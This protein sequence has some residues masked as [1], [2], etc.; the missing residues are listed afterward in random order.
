MRPGRR[1]VDRVNRNVFA[2]T[3][4]SKRPAQDV[5]DRPK[6]GITS[7]LEEVRA[8]RLIVAND[9]KEPGLLPPWPEPETWRL[10][11]SM[12]FR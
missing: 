9:R 6:Q 7:R 1:G 4:A 12:F 3:L 5:S 2:T 8:D 11:F 10:Q